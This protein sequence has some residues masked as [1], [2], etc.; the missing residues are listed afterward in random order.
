ML[1]IQNIIVFEDMTTCE[2]ENL[3]I[4]L[5]SS[6]EMNSYFHQFIIW[7]VDGICVLYN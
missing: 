6:Y 5:F 4:D 7:L 1:I 3:I 2:Q